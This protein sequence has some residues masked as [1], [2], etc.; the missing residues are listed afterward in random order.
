MKAFWPLPT[1]RAAI[2][3]PPSP[4][5]PKIRSLRPRQ[6]HA[7]RLRRRLAAFLLLATPAGPAAAAARSPNGRALSRRLRRRL[8]ARSG[9]HKRRHAG[10]PPVRDLLALPPAGRPA[11]LSRPPYINCP[12]RHPSPARQASRSEGG[13]LRRRTA[14]HAGD[15]RH[16]STWLARP[17]HFGHRLR[18]RAPPLRNHRPRLRA[19]AERG[20][21]RL[22]RNSRRWRPADNQRQ[23]RLARSRN[24]PGSRPDTC[25]VALLETWMRLGRIAHGPLFRRIAKKNAGVAAERLTDK[26]VARLA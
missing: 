17:R 22:D 2:L 23:D 8:W 3:S 7:A 1:S 18:R 14:R 24:R 16:G 12:R 10:A 11:R 15:A 5:R 26:H 20:R 19:Q 9:A 4:R 25:P 6:Q 13:D 21:N